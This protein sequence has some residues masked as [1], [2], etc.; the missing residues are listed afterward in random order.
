MVK[1]APLKLDAIARPAEPATPAA[2]PEP[3][4]PVFAR[5]PWSLAEELRDLARRR[6][7]ETGRRVTI[8]D[9][10]IEAVSKLVS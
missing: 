4:S 6:S 8:N 10:V 2:G 5:L 7:R 9:L 3:T 1:R